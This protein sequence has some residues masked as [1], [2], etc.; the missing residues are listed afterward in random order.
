[1]VVNSSGNTIGKVTSNGSVRNKSGNS[2]G[3]V[4][5]DITKEQAAAFF[6]FFF[7]DLV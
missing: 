6:F 5:G 2:I 1:T 4:R 3:S 7:T